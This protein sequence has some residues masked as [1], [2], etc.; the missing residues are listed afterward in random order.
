MIVRDEEAM[1]PGCLDSVRGVVDEIVVVDT[2]S[3]D[4]TVGV[5]Q[6][7]GAR[8]VPFA[9]CDDF[10]AARNAALP[11]VTADWILVLDADERLAADAGE[12]IRR[13]I[14]RGGF[15]VAQL[16]LYD[17]NRLDAA[18]E[19]VLN[20]VARDGEP[21]LI[22]RLF[23]RVPELRW[24]G[25]VH[26][27]VTRWGDEDVRTLGRLSAPIVHY[28]YSRGYREARGKADRNLRLL[29]RSRD[30]FPDDARI[31]MYLASELKGVRRFAEARTEIDVGWTLVRRAWAAGV[32]P[33]AVSV[34]TVRAVLL[35]GEGRG[36]EALAML[37][38]AAA[39]AVD[40]PNLD[41]L[42][43]W[44]LARRDPDVAEAAFVR[45]L[46]AAGHTFPEPV[47]P[48]ATGASARRALAAL[49]RDRG[50]LGRLE[51]ILA[52]DTDADGPSVALL[53]AEARVAVD[54]SG[55]RA[56]LATL[57]PSADRDLLQAAC[58]EALGDL[59]AMAA[60]LDACRGRLPLE[61]EGRVARRVHLELV[62]RGAAAWTSLTAAVGPAGDAESAAA[63]A[64]RALSSGD[65]RTC[66]GW[67]R[68]ALRVHPGN[69]QAWASWTLATQLAGHPAL[70]VAVA[71]AAVRAVPDAVELRVARML[72]AEA[73]G[74]R[75]GA[76]RRARALRRSN[77]G[78]PDADALLTRV[79]VHRAP[80]THGDVSV[81]VVVAHSGDSE[82]LTGLLD[83]LAL[84]DLPDGTLEVV[85][86]GVDGVLAPATGPR[87]FLL[88]SVRAETSAS[89]WDDGWRAAT[90]P[91]VVFLAEDAVPPPGAVRALLAGRVPAGVVQAASRL[92]PSC[93][94][95]VAS[96][97]LVDMDPLSRPSAGVPP[98]L[99]PCG[100]V[101]PSD[102][103]T[104]IGGLARELS[105]P[106]A[107]GLD[108]AARLEAAAVEVS[109]RPDVLIERAGAVSLDA[110]LR[111]QETLGAEVLALWRARGAAVEGGVRRVLGA[112]PDAAELRSAR[113]SGDGASADL[114]ERVYE[115]R[116][117]LARGLPGGTD[118]RV[119]L[120]RTAHAVVRWHRW[121]GAVRASDVAN[122]PSDA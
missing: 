30:L 84:Q 41:F 4:G 66:I 79:G 5:A 86:A 100:L 19:D 81:S 1:L 24:H 18:P 10:S 55:A 28:G 92:H 44:L 108:L 26:E 115:V 120:V 62:H 42:R 51:P 104:R 36:D 97:L 47:Y 94:D 16:P 76:V 71:E 91:C 119:A 114:A 116:H 109:H 9:W 23:R 83:A 48:G 17:A 118:A 29:R 40:H 65:V 78:H 61:D 110:H 14:A 89:A 60:A 93:V 90:A 37:D 32:R 49:A 106:W 20:G 54:P 27:G 58:A 107:V 11:H 7:A 39:H 121:R 73:T 87:P 63:A 98:M 74:D 38:E 77:G 57:A 43:G 34:V 99:S 95:D 102:V 68:A 70:A 22:S 52:L 101:V 35:E 13:A 117:T 33:F 64:A 53:R 8:V 21:T 88:R 72:L 75:L 67:A 113:A 69:V 46:D 80:V 25:I 122:M 105:H 3:T 56:L 112:V 103:L 59:P 85:V 45:A 15:D 111:A 31:R 50:D 82:A 96:L 6:A 12:R 2:G